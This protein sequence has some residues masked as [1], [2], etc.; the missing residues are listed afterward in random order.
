ML[1]EVASGGPL[2]RMRVAADLT[3]QS[4]LRFTKYLFYAWGLYFAVGAAERAAAKALRRTPR[5]ATV[6]ELCRRHGIECL[7]A[8]R[9]ND[10]AVVDVLAS[11]HLDVIVTLQFDQI[12]GPEVI[13]A[14]RS[15]VLNV[16][17]S[18]LPSGRGKYPAIAR[19]LDPGARTG[20]TVHRIVDRGI[21]TGP[22]LRQAKVVLPASTSLLRGESRI[23]EAGVDAL[24]AVLDDLGGH[25]ERQRPQERALDDDTYYSD[26]TREEVAAVVRQGIPLATVRDVVGLALPA[27]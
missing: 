19:A 27:R 5:H 13:R 2:E 17:P 21:D 12:L 9:V 7:T 16:H 4:G 11:R 1:S 8:T 20:V 3:R 10:P 15:F 14:A 25:V 22:I 23:F 24:V 26:P 18:W 6:E